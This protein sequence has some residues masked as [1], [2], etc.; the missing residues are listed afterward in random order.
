MSSSVTMMKLAVSFAFAA[1]LLVR[2]Y[3]IIADVKK[4]NEEKLWLNRLFDDVMT[5]LH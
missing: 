2:M 3:Q 4:D 1:L 5:P